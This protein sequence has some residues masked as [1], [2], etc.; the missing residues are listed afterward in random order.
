MQL[1]LR[2]VGLAA[3]AALAQAGSVQV[4]GLT[5]P[6]SSAEDRASVV[7]IFNNS[8]I[9]YR[10]ANETSDV[11][12]SI[13]LRPEI[14]GCRSNF[15]FGHDE[16][17]PLSQQPLDPRNGWGAT[18]V[19]AMGTMVCRSRYL[20]YVFKFNNCLSTSWDSQYD[21]YFLLSLLPCLI[22]VLN[23]GLF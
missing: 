6:P 12:F 2:A 14:V 1:F 21:N 3:V 19:D 17:A 20:P 18:I 22:G 10:C 8:Y 23:L 15:A 7:K 13:Y 11:F 16:V 5:V 4:P 9:A